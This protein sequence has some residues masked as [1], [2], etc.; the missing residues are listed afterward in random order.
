[1]RSET[2]DSQNTHHVAR[3]LSIPG[4]LFRIPFLAQPLIILAF[5]SWARIPFAGAEAHSKPRTRNTV[6]QPLNHWVKF[7]QVL[8]CEKRQKAGRSQ[9]LAA[10]RIFDGLLAGTCVPS[11][12]RRA[13]GAVRERTV[14]VSPALVL[15]LCCAVG[16]RSWFRVCGVVIVVQFRVWCTDN[17]LV[18]GFLP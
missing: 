11:S 13:Q 6:A 9:G 12:W 2:Q 17:G 5:H 7:C 4:S 3:P 10:R 16:L 8:E 14:Q 15:G 18:S 1:M